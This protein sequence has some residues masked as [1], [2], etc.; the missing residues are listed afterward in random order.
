MRLRENTEI[1]A[2]VSGSRLQEADQELGIG[3]DGE[4]KRIRCD[5]L[6]TVGSNHRVNIRYIDLSEVNAFV[7]RVGDD[8]QQVD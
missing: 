5:L 1:D 6:T 7:V 3:S 2:L 8:S 4:R